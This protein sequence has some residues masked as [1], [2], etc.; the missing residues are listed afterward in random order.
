MSWPPDTEAVDELHK[1]LFTLAETRGDDEAIRFL[2]QELTRLRVLKQLKARSVALLAPPA[3]DTAKPTPDLRL[4]A[5]A[6]DFYADPDNYRPKGA[7]KSSPVARDRG[8]KA[9]DA[10]TAIAHDGDEKE[11]G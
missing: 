3:G 1:A 5:D 11:I 2:Q 8:R 7:T 9:R 6:L 4:A 10:L